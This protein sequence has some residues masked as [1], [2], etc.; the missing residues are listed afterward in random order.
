MATGWNNSPVKKMQGVA[1]KGESGIGPPAA[2]TI[3]LDRNPL[4]DA[5]LKLKTIDC[6]FDGLDVSGHGKGY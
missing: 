2:P 5:V 4:L 6:P 3:G 1:E